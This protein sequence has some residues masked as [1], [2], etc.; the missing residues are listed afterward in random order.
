[1]STLH[2]RL[3]L[4]ATFPHATLQRCLVDASATNSTTS[5]N[6]L[7]NTDLAIHGKHMLGYYVSDYIMTR[8]PRLP[9]KVVK[10]TLNS[11]AGWKTLASVCKGWG[12]ETDSHEPSSTTRA[13]S[14]DAKLQMRRVPKGQTKEVV[15][16]A[17]YQDEAYA[18]FVRSV[19]GA[20]HIHAGPQGVRQFIDHH[21]L[22][23][24]LDIL[25][26]FRVSEPGREL[27][28]LCLREGLD[29]P[30]TRLIAESGR[31]TNSP[32]FVQAVYTG[33]EKLSEGQG[34]SL[35]ESKFIAESNALK[36][37]LM[38]ED[39]QATLSSTRLENDSQALAFKPAMVD[40]GDIIV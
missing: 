11:F 39:R 21:I 32:V 26:S 33:Q 22:S 34:A 19:I 30:T 9:Y 8:Y 4:P 6:A 14:S 18:N 1:M 16:G 2:A 13:S 5:A 38:F 28:H 15:N 36:S 17:K 20:V 40:T 3:A 23:R 7:N 31:R 24:D 35:K 37:W 25:R 12:V 10:N 29:R 27:S